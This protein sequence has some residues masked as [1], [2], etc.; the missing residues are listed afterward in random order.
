MKN[1]LKLTSA[2]LMASAFIATPLYAQNGNANG[3]IENAPGQMKMDDGSKSA[4]EYAPG[5]AV[6]GGEANNASDLAPGRIDPATTASINLTE[7]QKSELSTA[8][9][10]VDSDPVDVDFDAQIGATAP[11]TITLKPLPSQVGGIIPDYSDHQYFVSADG[12]IVIVA[13]DTRKVV[14]VVDQA[15]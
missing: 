1:I 6:K 13:P 8:F 3:A 10:D 5:Q 4:S 2:A 12:H 15:T 9:A 14:Y 7:S 11:D